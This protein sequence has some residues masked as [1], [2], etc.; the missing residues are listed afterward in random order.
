MSDRDTYIEGRRFRAGTMALVDLVTAN[1]DP[2]VFEDPGRFDVRRP[3]A[4]KH[5]SFAAG[6]HHCLGASLARMEAQI[7]FT[8]LLERFDHLE[9]A[10]APRRRKTFILR[11]Y[12]SIPIRGSAR[13]SP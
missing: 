11:G 3:N 9:P 2:A 4:A 1:R 10:G 12:R 8:A 6:P 7:A 5:L 13:V